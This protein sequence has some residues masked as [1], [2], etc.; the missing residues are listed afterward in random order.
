MSSQ[1]V[2]QMVLNLAEEAGSVLTGRFEAA[3][4]RARV[5][6]GAANGDVVVDLQGVNVISPSFAD[7]FFA[8]LP[9]ELIASGKIQFVHLTSE[10]AAIVRTVTAGRAHLSASD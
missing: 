8:K 6:A 9:P 3:G 10:F 2:S 4:M 7:E 1:M 5:V